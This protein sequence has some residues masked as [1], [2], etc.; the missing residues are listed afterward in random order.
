M[1]VVLILNIP[2]NKK[3]T[4]APILCFGSVYKRLLTNCLQ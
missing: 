4:F 2:F 3:N 1:D